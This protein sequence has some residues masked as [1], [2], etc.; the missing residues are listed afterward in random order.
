M[1]KK[2]VLI[3]FLI[4]ISVLLINWSILISVFNSLPDIITT[5][6]NVLGE[7][8]R[9]GNK[10]HLIYGL[11]VNTLVL[12]IVFFFIKNPKYANYPIE[13]NDSNRESMHLKM[14]YFLSIVG[15]FTSIA[16]SF[17]ITQTFNSKTPIFLILGYSIVSPILSLIF[18]KEK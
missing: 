10:V 3:F 18:F 7:A 14:Q 2:T 4:A 16:F 12:A 9:Y 15:I 8:N 5:H 1:I 11:I 17:M 6:V 13:L